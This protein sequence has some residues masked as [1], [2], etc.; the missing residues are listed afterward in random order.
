MEWLHAFGLCHDSMSHIDL[1][2]FFLLN[3][4][5]LIWYIQKNKLFLSIIKRKWQQQVNIMATS[6]SGLRK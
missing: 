6:L 5:E 3:N 2:D 4:Q 1:L